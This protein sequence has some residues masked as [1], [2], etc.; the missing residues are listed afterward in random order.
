MFIKNKRGPQ[1]RS[2]S[3]FLPRNTPRPKL[4]TL[5]ESSTTEP[6]A[7]IRGGNLDGKILY[8][9]KNPAERGKPKKGADNLLREKL[10]TKNDPLSLL[11]RKWFVR[12]GYTDC[13]IRALLYAYC[14]KLDGQKPRLDAEKQKKF[15]DMLDAIEEA[16]GKEICLGDEGTLRPIPNIKPYGKAQR[17]TV[18]VTG[19]SGAGKSHWVGQYLSLY[20]K[21]FPDFPI[22]VFST[23]GEDPALDKVPGVKRVKLDA[24]F[25]KTP[26]TCDQVTDGH[27]GACCVFDDISVIDDKKVREAAYALESK[28]LEIGRHA[29]ITLCC[30][31]HQASDYRKT[32]TLLNETCTFV[33]F[34]R[35]G[36]LQHVRRVLGPCYLGLAKKDIDKLLDLGTVSRWVAVSKTAPYIALYEKGALILAN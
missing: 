17:E 6:C 36:G 12:K 27:G 3:F 31:E 9:E 32:R 30:T 7:Q 5:F 19:P 10:F 4:L 13:M 21:L 11:G 25:A 22:F 24:E 33:F 20:R 29:C 14:E 23:V 35:A 8:V 18:Y 34:P 26:I 28:L 15:E 2:E 16:I 1:A